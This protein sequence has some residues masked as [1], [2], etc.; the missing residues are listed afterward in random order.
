ME[1]RKGRT[2]EVVKI[3]RTIIDARR[4]LIAHRHA[5]GDTFF[6]SP[7]QYAAL[8]DAQRAGLRYALVQNLGDG[9]ETG[10]ETYQGEDG[11]EVPGE[12]GDDESYRYAYAGGPPPFD[13]DDDEDAYR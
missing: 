5:G 9:P 6:G 11:E 3:P 2:R 8:S 12:A 10:G 13:D 1:G 7:E 4:E